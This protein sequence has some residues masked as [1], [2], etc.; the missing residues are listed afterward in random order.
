M[1]HYFTQFLNKIG[2]TPGMVFRMYLAAVLFQFS[3]LS[4]ASIHTPNT[5][6]AIPFL[7][8]IAD[9]LF[10]AKYWWGVASLAASCGMLFRYKLKAWP[11]GVLTADLLAI[12][13]FGFLGYDYATDKPPVF[14]GSILAVTSA[15]FLIGGILDER[16][17]E[18]LK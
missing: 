17:R 9:T 12:A 4:F 10:V 8:N 2:N 13:S 11:A 6:S 14:A 15:V 7:D 5:N 1:K 3:M 16:R 18:G